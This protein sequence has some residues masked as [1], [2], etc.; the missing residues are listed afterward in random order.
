[1]Q[2]AMPTASV[3]V[4]YGSFAGTGLRHS[5]SKQAE[6]GDFGNMNPADG[7][8]SVSAASIGT[9]TTNNE[10][11]IAGEVCTITEVKTDGPAAL[12]HISYRKTRPVT[13]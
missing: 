10:I 1:M 8:V 12:V 5:V 7:I 2:G 11:T 6:Q 13:P 9:V 3:V 4:V